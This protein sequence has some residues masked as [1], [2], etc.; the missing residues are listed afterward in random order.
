MPRWERGLA[1][2]EEQRIRERAY[3]I[4]EQEGRPRGRDLDHRL[5]AEAEIAAEKSR[6]RLMAA[7][8][9]AEIPARSSGVMVE[10][11]PGDTGKRSQQHLRND[12]RGGIT[13]ARKTAESLFTARPKLPEELTREGSAPARKP[14]VLPIVSA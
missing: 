9:T 5:R 12:G 14:R 3:S 8:E 10:Q 6:G 4:W 1:V 11:F 7:K 13:R 2:E